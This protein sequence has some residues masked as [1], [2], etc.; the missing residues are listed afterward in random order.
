MVVFWVG[1]Q[2]AGGSY[3]NVKMPGNG[4]RGRVIFLFFLGHHIVTLSSSSHIG[5]FIIC[6]TR[7]TISWLGGV[8]FDLALKLYGLVLHAFSS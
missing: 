7:T 6:L 5:G 3:G 1:K 8:W 2:A 4:F